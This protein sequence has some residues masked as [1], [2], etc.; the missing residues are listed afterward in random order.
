LLAQPAEEL[1][2]GANLAIKSAIAASPPAGRQP[3]IE[4]SD[5]SCREFAA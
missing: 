3:S 2:V 5:A 4:A 1:P